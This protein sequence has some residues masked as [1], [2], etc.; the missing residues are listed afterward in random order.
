MACAGRLVAS[1]PYYDAQY[2]V[3]DVEIRKPT[4]T[5]YGLLGDWFPQM[6]LAVFVV[7]LILSLFPGVRRAL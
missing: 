1:L 7:F 3:V 4:L 2:L 5:L 6:L